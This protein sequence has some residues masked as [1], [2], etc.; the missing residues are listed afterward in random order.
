MKTNTRK[1]VLLLFAVLVIAVLAVIIWHT[2]GV[3]RAVH[4]E[5]STV[6]MDQL[7]QQLGGEKLTRQELRNGKVVVDGVTLH[8]AVYYP[9]A[10]TLVCFLENENPHRDIYLEGLPDK[11]GGAFPERHGI[12]FVYFE[13]VSPADLD[14][15]LIVDMTNWDFDTSNPVSLPLFG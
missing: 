8:R 13:A 12:S 14:R 9:Q 15:A 2:V 3:Y 7:E 1:R 6:H 10:E 5:I 11:N 4:A